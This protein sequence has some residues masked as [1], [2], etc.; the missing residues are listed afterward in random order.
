[1]S[2][3]A[4]AFCG[5]GRFARALGELAAEANLAVRAWDPAAPP[6]EPFRVD[7]PAALCLGADVVVVA[8]P[9]PAVEAALRSL[10]PHLLP[11]TLVLDVAS[12]KLEPVA[13]LER[14]LGDAVPWVGTHPLFGP[15]SLARGEPRTVIVCPSP[16]HPGAASGARALFEALGCR[17]V[18]ETPDA[19][20]LRMAE[21]HALAFFLAKAMLDAHVPVDAQAVPASFA[22]LASVVQAVRSDAGHLLP[23]ITR[24]NPYAAAARRR[25]LVALSAVDRTLAEAGGDEHAGATVATAPVLEIPDLGARSP[26]LRETREHIEELDREL[27]LLL[28]RR[29]ELARRAARAKSALGVG[30]VDPTRERALLADRRAWA[31]ELGLP[32]DQLE[33]VF[34]AVVRMSR[35]VQET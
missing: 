22:A 26:A 28:G 33:E 24:A 10:R 9:V 23:A 17:V 35:K 27:A 18:E 13:A 31:E 21:T 11:P 12:V 1:M 8:V 32:A 34:R 30:I 15:T 6:P 20:D 2:R 7:T 16:L 29:A 3:I 25:L 5:F 4:I 14:V 19:H